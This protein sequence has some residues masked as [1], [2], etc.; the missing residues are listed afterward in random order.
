VQ[1]TSAVTDFRDSAEVARVHPT[2]IERLLLDLTSGQVFRDEAPVNLTPIEF[3]LLAYLALE[4]GRPVSR[5][6]IAQLLWSDRGHAQA[7]DSL[8][9]SLVAL[10]AWSKTQR[11]Q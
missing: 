11:A 8:R 10:H 6:R 2:E 7:R 9:Q 1:H 4:L 5:E 3:R